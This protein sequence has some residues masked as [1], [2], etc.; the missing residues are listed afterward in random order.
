MPPP[1]LSRGPFVRATVTNFFVTASLNAFV[2]L[3]L[4]IHELGGTDVEVGIVMGVYS[5]VGIVAQPLVGPWVDALG[6]RPFM[7][8]GVGLAL[9]GALLA[10][11]GSSIAMLGF[12]RALQGVGFSLFFVASFAYVL[13]L[14]PSAQRGWALGIYG[15]SGFVSTALAPLVGEW[16]IRGLGF[17]ALAAGSALLA[18]VAGALLWQ[19][20]PARRETAPLTG[21]GWTRS[22]LDDVVQRP[23]AVAAF[24]GLGTGTIFAFVPTFAE[25]LGVRTLALFYTAYAVAAMGVRIGGGQLVDTR[26]RRAVIVPSMFAQAVAS[27]VLAAVGLLVTGPSHLPLLP[28]LFFTGLLSGA[29]HGFLYPGLAALVTDRTPESRRGAVVGTFSAVLLA[30]QAAGAF[31]FGYVSHAAGYGIMWSWL[32]WLLLIGFL[33]SLRLLGP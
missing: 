9:V 7:L 10:L 16:I 4:R 31:A 21:P 28:A 24:F 5:A 29:A 25:S 22:A 33:V 20:V 12:V 14:V 30:G 8:I 2:L 15:V 19:L 13:D 26:G 6:R 23:M 27:G 18:G 1:I 3:P 32:T 17:R 11:V